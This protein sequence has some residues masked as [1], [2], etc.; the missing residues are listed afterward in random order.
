M[1]DTATLMVIGLTAIVT[2]SLRLGGLLL[3]AKL[4]QAG[5]FKQF[6]DALPGTVLVA[7]VAPGILNS[8]VWGGIAAFCTGLCAY[9][10]KNMFLAMLVGVVIVALS[11]QLQ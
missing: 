10:T 4:P 9:K 3:A 1:S 5:R 7:L 8:G 2:Y 11:R 6:M